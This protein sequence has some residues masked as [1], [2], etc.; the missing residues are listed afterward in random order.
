MSIIER[1][2]L[3]S[4]A[5][6]TYNGAEFLAPQLD[7]LIN[8]TYKNLEIVICDD[9]STD[10]THSIIEAYQKLDSRIKFFPNK[11]NLGFNL[12][13]ERT[14]KHCSGE[15]IAISDQD[16]IWLL[17]KIEIVLNAWEE[18]VML[19]HHSTKTFENEPLPDIE[20]TNEVMAFSGNCAETLLRSNT[21]QG[22]TIVF[23]KEIL[24]I[25]LPFASNV[26][27][28]WW[29]AVCAVSVGK[30]QYLHRNLI[31]HRRHLNSAHYSKSKVK[32]K[33][34]Y[35]EEHEIFLNLVLDRLSLTP[36][37]IGF[38]NYYLELLE[39]LKVSW[40]S[41][42]AFAFFFRNGKFFFSRKKK[43][44]PYFSYLIHSYKN[45]RGLKYYGEGTDS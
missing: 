29:L 2:P 7:T 31:Y 6:A 38:V 5:V 44:F 10:N 39:V 30:I 14:L 36:R 16:D 25:A 8:Q 32:S 26:L 40:F 35:L 41:F 3:V 28:D 20:I 34:F 4:I 22:C 18:G 45:S 24:T 19:V 27:Y 17:D 23:K 21:V 12:N 33:L 13:F 11:E 43:L 15:F 1:N 37:V 42:R 9:A